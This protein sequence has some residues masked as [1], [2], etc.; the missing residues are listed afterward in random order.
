MPDYY[1]AAETIRA[2]VVAA[3]RL[4]DGQEC[5]IPAYMIRALLDAH[6][7]AY[8]AAIAKAEG[9]AA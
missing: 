9:G 1:E 5:N 3:E 7:K 4:D 6:R 8:S 2:H